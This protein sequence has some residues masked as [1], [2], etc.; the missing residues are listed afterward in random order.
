MNVATS[1]QSR[2]RAGHFVGAKLTFS[3]PD[4]EFGLIAKVIIML[5]VLRRLYPVVP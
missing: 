5:P 4:L 1:F 2:H 3:V